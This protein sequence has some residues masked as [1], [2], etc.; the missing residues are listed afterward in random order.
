MTLEISDIGALSLS[1]IALVEIRSDAEWI[2]TFRKMT[3]APAARDAIVRIATRHS[4]DYRPLLKSA[5]K[6]FGA[7]LFRRT[8]GGIK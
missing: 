4:R 2:R 5:V 3:A 7:E 8:N 1:R 6:K